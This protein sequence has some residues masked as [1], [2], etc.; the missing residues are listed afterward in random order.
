MH[1]APYQAVLSCTPRGDVFHWVFH[2]N[3]IKEGLIWISCQVIHKNIHK[4]ICFSCSLGSYVD[5][6]H[7]SWRAWHGTFPSQ[8]QNANLN[9]PSDEE[10]YLRKPSITGLSYWRLQ[11]GL[12][13]LKQFGR[14]W[15]RGETPDWSIYVQTTDLNCSYI[16]SVDDINW[17]I[18]IQGLH[19]SGT[20]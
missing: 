18:V 1:W 13:S 14:Q 3:W 7:A 17:F 12:Y 16:M 15:Y 10:I 4:H 19:G 20:W 9:G 2:I 6:I 11:N 5:S 8:H